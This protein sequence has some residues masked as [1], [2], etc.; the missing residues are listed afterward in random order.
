MDI[1]KDYLEKKIT[2]NEAYRI[3]DLKVEKNPKGIPK[4][5]G[6]SNQEWTAYCFGASIVTLSKWRN[7]GWPKECS[8]CG[9]SLDFTEYNWIVSNNKLIGT[10]CH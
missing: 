1:L 9:S 8:I 10:R 5:L 2:I 3:I 4:V 6:L 7:K